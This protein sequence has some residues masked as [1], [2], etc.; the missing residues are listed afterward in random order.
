MKNVIK[1][2]IKK[3]NYL[4]HINRKKP[5]I[6]IETNIIIY[7]C[8]KCNKDFKYK[9]SY[10]YHI[11]KINSCIT[12]SVEEKCNNLEIELFNLK[13]ESKFTDNKNK[14]LED[15]RNKYNEL[16][17]NKNKQLEDE[18]K[19]MNKLYNN[20]LDK[21]IKINNKKTKTKDND[22]IK[23]KLIQE[24]VYII[25]E[26]DFVQLN[27]DIYKI[28]RT[29]KE[30]PEDRFQT[31]RKG[32]EIVAFFKVNNSIECEYKMIKCL[33][34]HPNIKKMSEHGKEYFQG[35]RNELINEIVQIVKNYN[36]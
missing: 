6:L 26:S 19:K 28:G 10:L 18:N 11:N 5:C 24:Y 36:T 22:D 4:K 14:I 27:K 20:L 3:S 35:N 25:R 33:S 13:K 29:A 16:L 8:E 12:I 7:K 17:I 1:N 15:E 2:L 34:N 21:F 31:Y 32:I 9:T 30:N 23:I